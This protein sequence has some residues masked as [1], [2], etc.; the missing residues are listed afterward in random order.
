M[1]IFIAI[2]IIIFLFVTISKSANKSKNKSL[3]STDK[4]KEYPI[5]ITTSYEDIPSTQEEKFR[6]ITQDAKGYWILNPGAPFELTLVNA[7]KDTA[8]E[9]RDI[10]DN[11][12]INDYQKSDKLIAVF[13]GKNI[14]VNEIEE[15]KERYRKI[16]L[17]KLEELK[18][19][20]PEWS[21]LGDKDKE[22]LL[23]NFRK[24]AIDEIYEKA[25]C[26]LEVLFES[27]PQDITLDDDLINDY[28][29]ENIQTYLNYASNL[30]KIRVIP[31]GSYSRP[32]FEK[33]AEYG[34]AVR[35]HELKKEEILS[36][37]TLKELNVIANYPEKEYKRKKQAIEYILTIDDLDS[38]IGKYVALRELFKLNPLPS[39]YS[40][41]D[42]QDILSTWDY[43]AQEVRLL[44][45]T[46]RN[47]YYSWREL[48]DTK[49]VKG[50]TV[51]TLYKEYPCNCAKELSKKK[52]SKNMPPKVPCHIGCTS[53][54]H[55]E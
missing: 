26:D 49:Y 1:E 3:V 12:E 30:D 13:A 4:K 29:F 51:E 10:L 18:E 25:D 39:K 54:L 44:M 19:K 9:V 43:H 27:E 50:Y 53:L 6:P 47:S 35:G 22:D 24:I 2:L 21:S 40:Y 34:L 31:N 23:I 41:I 38:T 28:G 5:K 15:Y 16:Y 37:L 8:Q 7:D 52:Y 48:K 14:R 45:D 32:M 17:L 55:K 33:L 46:Y 11:E 42:L 36:T 20:S